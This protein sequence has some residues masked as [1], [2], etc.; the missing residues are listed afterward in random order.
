MMASPLAASSSR[1][2]TPQSPLA[3]AA[4][5]IDDLTVALSNFSRA[6]TPDPVIVCCCRREECESTRAWA[7]FRA[8]LES[9]LV[10]SAGSCLCVL[11]LCLNSPCVEVGQALLQRHEA[12]VRRQDAA[13]SREVSHYPSLTLCTDMFS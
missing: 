11:E 2:S 10:L 7:S 5:T 1:A 6:P 9:R 4:T 13:L 8:K 12:Y 3:K